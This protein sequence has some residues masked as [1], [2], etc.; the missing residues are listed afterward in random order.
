MLFSLFATFNLY[1]KITHPLLVYGRSVVGKFHQSG[2]DSLLLWVLS[3]SP[4]RS[5]YERL[6]GHPL[7]SKLLE[8]DGFANQITAYG[9]LDI[10]DML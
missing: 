10:R 1:Y 3:D 6:G 5:F 7:E 9:W 4:Y 2:I 8:M